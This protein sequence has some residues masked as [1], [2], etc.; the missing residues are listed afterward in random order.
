MVSNMKPMLFPF[1]QLS[2]TFVWDIIFFYT[3]SQLEASP[4]NLGNH[5]GTRLWPKVEEVAEKI[6]MGFYP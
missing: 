4:T 5:T 2:L 1:G 6:K 3:F